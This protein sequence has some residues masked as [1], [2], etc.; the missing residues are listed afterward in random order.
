M[1]SVRKRSKDI[2]TKI[3]FSVCFKTYAIHCYLV[4]IVK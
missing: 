2:K 1:I 3:N 4:S